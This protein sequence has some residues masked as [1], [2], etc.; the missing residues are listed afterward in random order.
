[1]KTIPGIIEGEF[2]CELDEEHSLGIMTH[3]DRIVEI[4]GVDMSFLRG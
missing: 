4:G 3:L 2:G 1:M